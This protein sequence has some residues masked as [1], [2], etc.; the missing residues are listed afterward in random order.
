M[1]SS[2]MTQ[3]TVWKY[4]KASR[5]F[6]F[7]LSVVCV[8]GSYVV[9]RSHSP[10]YSPFLLSDLIQVFQGERVVCECGDAANV[11]VLSHCPFVL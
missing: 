6:L 9:G 4:R 2:C 5:L 3:M 10:F 7:A 8:S 11:S 1:R